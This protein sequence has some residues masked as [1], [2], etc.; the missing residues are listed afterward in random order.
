[1][2]F[3]DMIELTGLR[4]F[5]R[6]GVFDFER[7]NGQEFVVDLR[8]GVSTTRAAETD[9]VADTVH[10]GE[11]AEKVVGIVGGEPVNLI[12]TLAHRIADA[13]M[14]DERIDF[15]I[16]TVH[17]PQAPIEAQFQDVSVTVHASRDVASARERADVA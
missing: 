14:G 5:G 3:A 13:V 1:M 15:L 17:K 16:V 6:H 10:Y 9:D 7:E 4:A 12:E 2:N 8:L 11:L